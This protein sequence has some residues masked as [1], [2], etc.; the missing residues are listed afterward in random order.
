MM[1]RYLFI[2]LLIVIW[3]SAALGQSTEGTSGSAGG[4]TMSSQAPAQVWT[5]N[6]ESGVYS[7]WE[8]IDGAGVVQSGQGNVLGFSSAGIAAWAVQPGGDYTLTLRIRQ[9]GGAPEIMLSHRHDPPDEQYYIVRLFPDEAEVVKFNGT[10][11]SS[12]G[13]VGGKGIGASTW[14]S[15]EVSMSGG[16]QSIIVNVGGQPL[17]T[18]QD[19]QPLKPGAISFRAVGEGGTE[20][21]DLV[22]TPGSV[23]GGSQTGQTLEPAQLLDPTKQ[24]EPA[25]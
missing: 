4:T 7:N 9:G 8:F 3:C 21:D 14:T 10:Q 6:F 16:G 18:V 20:I 13:F 1:K 23:S 12:L 19:P 15:V 5:E 2:S 17:L 22:L 25:Q 24:S 11:H